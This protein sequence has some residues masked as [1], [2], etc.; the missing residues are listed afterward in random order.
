MSH[1]SISFNT[2]LRFGLKE[3][4]LQCKYWKTSK[5]RR[6]PSGCDSNSQPTGK[7]IVEYKNQI[8]GYDQPCESSNEEVTEEFS[9]D[10]LEES[11]SIKDGL[12]E[13]EKVVEN[14]SEGLLESLL[15]KNDQISGMNI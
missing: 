3:Q 14:E 6:C 10:E 13:V 4:F 5:A 11:E 12:E 9:E 15:Q 8:C 2:F 1:F 7:E